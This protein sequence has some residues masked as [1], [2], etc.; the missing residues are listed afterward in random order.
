ML[1]FPDAFLRDHAARLRERLI[2]WLRRLAPARVRTFDPWTQYEIH[3]DH[4]EV[5]RMACEAAAFSCF[6][7]LHPEHLAEGLEPR[8][9]NE[10]WLMTPQEHRPNRVVDIAATLQVKID[11]LLC[12]A[13]QLEMLADWFV[14]GADPANLTAAELKGLRS[15]AAGYLETMARAE[16]GFAKGVQLGE[17]FYALRVGPGHFD[18]YRDM[19]TESLGVPPPD[20]E[21]F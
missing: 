21:V 15:G 4:I 20:A 1:G 8:Q 17:A 3:P 16:A 2:Y 9:P 6:P 10:V 5:G 12:H 11:S 18:N 7:L 13:S 19:V 14:P